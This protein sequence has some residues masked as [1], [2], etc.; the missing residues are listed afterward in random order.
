M[1]AGTYILVTSSNREK[2]PSFWTVAIWT[3]LG[4]ITIEI[5]RRN[6]RRLMKNIW[7]QRANFLRASGVAATVTV[8][9]TTTPLVISANATSGTVS[10]DIAIPDA[11]LFKRDEKGKICPDSNHMGYPCFE[12]ESEDYFR[13]STYREKGARYKINNEKVKAFM[14]ES[15]YRSPFLIQYSNSVAVWR[16]GIGS[17]VPIT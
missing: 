17:S 12:V 2:N 7:D 11:H 14:R 3:L 4:S 16:N 6:P 13:A 5:V 8:L 10:T 15:G 1:L 9:A